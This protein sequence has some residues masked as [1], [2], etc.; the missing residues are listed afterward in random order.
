MPRALL[1]PCGQISTQIPRLFTPAGRNLANPSTACDLPPM[2]RE[3][4]R[5]R[6]FPEGQDDAQ[7]LQN[8]PGGKALSGNRILTHGAGVC[9]LLP[10]WLIALKK[11]AG[12]TQRSKNYKSFG[13]EK[14]CFCKPGG[15]NAVPPA[16]GSFCSGIALPPSCRLPGKGPSSIARGCSIVGGSAALPLPLLLPLAKY[17][18]NE[19]IPVARTWAPALLGARLPAASSDVGKP[20]EMATSPSVHRHQGLARGRRPLAAVQRPFAWG[21]Q[22]AASLLQHRGCAGPRAQTAAVP[23]CPPCPPLPSRHTTPCRPPLLSAPNRSPRRSHFDPL[24]NSSFPL[25]S[26]QALNLLAEM[27][28]SND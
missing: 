6:Q 21:L 8:K 7:Q 22:L 15:C 4:S 28:R 25:I 16:P 27:L 17:L 9:P 1:L 23:G 5:E 20:P 26:D 24:L 13:R 3:I 11:A 2:K 12:S 10:P 18:F 19:G 14:L